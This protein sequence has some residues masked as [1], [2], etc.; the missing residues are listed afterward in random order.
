MLVDIKEEEK[1]AAKKA[2]AVSQITEH[3][4]GNKTYFTGRELPGDYFSD[5]GECLLA[6]QEATRQRGYK[7]AGLNKHGQTPAD[8]RFTAK[9][10]AL[11]KDREKAVAAVNKID[12]QIAQLNRTR[13]APAPAPQKKVA[14]KKA[15]KKKTKGKK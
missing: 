6:N 10:K 5:Y 14:K 3:R 9:K 12:V 15:P 4:V 7:A 11:F 1:K 2:A 13:R 8:A